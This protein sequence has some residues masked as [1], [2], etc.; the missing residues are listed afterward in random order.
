MHRIA[1]D[2]DQTQGAA[3]LAGAED[4][5]VMGA[6]RVPAYGARAT[7]KAP[8][9]RSEKEV[10]GHEPMD[11]KVARRRPGFVETGKK[12]RDLRWPGIGTGH[13][14]RAG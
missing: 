2:G 14:A 12:C 11:R 9:R 10:T 3:G 7:V 4:H 1:M 5:M 13:L 8:T 6:K